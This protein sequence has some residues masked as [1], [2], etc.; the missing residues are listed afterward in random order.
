[1]SESRGQFVR[2]EAYHATDASGGVIFLLFDSEGG[3]VTLASSEQVV[4]DTMNSA[5][6]ASISAD[7]FYDA[8]LANTTTTGG[9]PAAGNRLYPL[10]AGIA[11]IRQADACEGM[12]V[13]TGLVPRLKASGI[14]AISVTAT[15]HIIRTRT[16]VIGG[17][18]YWKRTG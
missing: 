11:N 5:Y 18:P 16:E 17:V 13:P 6:T 3:A 14:G 12:P 15:G 1:M 2:M 8:A 4:I 10:V 7:I 9:T